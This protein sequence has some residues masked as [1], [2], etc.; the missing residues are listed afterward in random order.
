MP[1]KKEKTKYNLEYTYNEK[2]LSSLGNKFSSLFL[3][4]ES[5]ALIG[6]GQIMLQ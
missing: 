4:S 6:L 1:N 2:L 5:I 3:T